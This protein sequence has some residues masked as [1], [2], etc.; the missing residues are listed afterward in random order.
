MRRVWDTFIFSSELDLLEARLIELDS[1]V[2][3]HVLVEAPVT[4]QG[5]PKPLYFAENKERFSA[6]QDKIIHI[7]AD[8]PEGTPS[9]RQSAQDEAIG[10]GLD[11][12][13][14]DDI[15]MVS[16]AD[17]IPRA[18]AI[19][20]A[21]GYVLPMRHHKLAV[22]LIDIGWWK[23]TVVA[24][25]S[26]LPDSIEALRA[27]RNF[28][29]MPPLRDEMGWVVDGGW[30][31]SWLGGPG[32]IREKARG[33]LHAE[34]TE[35]ITAAAER[36]WREKISPESGVTRL[37]EVVVDGSFPRFMQER[38]GPASWYWPGE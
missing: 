11:G 7:V 3:R 13:R 8:L 19:Q 16:D 9:D 5:D 1:A 18:T 32:A 22:N 25:G 34:K 20:K 24:L 30:H 28:E 33:Y 31:F 12:L 36:L 23:G 26:E 35:G 14:D 10:Q 2:Y 29:D 27:F 15:F 4:F 21:P 37:L 17:E 38:Q 6:W